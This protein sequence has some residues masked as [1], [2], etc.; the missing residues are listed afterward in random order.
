MEERY[1]KREKKCVSRFL[2]AFPTILIL[3]S[4]ILNELLCVSCIPSAGHMALN[5]ACFHG[6]STGMVI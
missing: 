2:S 6:N 5:Q 4:Q 1:L 3:F